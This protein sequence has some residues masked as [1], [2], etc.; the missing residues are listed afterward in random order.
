M[1]G[2]VTNR[3]GDARVSGSLLRIAHATLRPGCPVQVVD[4]SPAGAQ[5]DSERPLRPGSRVHV[6]VVTAWRTLSVAALVLRCQVWSI[7]PQDG[8]TY[9][10][11]LG[12]EER[13]DAFWEEFTRGGYHVLAAEG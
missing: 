9:R 10:G 12:F 7:H 4:M 2:T 1:D 5:V 6:R 11:A 8:V 13:C 3:R